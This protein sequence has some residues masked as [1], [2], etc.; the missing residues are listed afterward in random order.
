MTAAPDMLELRAISAQ[1]A[2]W[3]TDLH[4]PERSPA[5]EAGV[6]RWLAEDPRNAQAFEL[7]TEAWQRSSNLPAH[8][9]DQPR[10]SVA[11]GVLLPG[12]PVRVRAG[13]YA[14]AG[15]AALCGIFDPH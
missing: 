1:A 5:L 14:F 11:L 8:L 10:P 15:A 2:V 4:G 3:V 12:R 6:R 7:A 13:R 9:P